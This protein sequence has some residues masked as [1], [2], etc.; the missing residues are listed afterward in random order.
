M[1]ILFQILLLSMFLH[2]TE[3]SSL[4][5]SVGLYWLLI[6]FHSYKQLMW[7][8]FKVFIELFTILFLSY[9]LGFFA[10]RHVRFYLPDQTCT[11]C[12]RRR[13][14]N[15]WTTTEV[16]GYP[17]W[18]KQCVHIHPK[19]PR[20]YSWD[21]SWFTLL[22]LLVVIFPYLFLTEYSGHVAHSTCTFTFSPPD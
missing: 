20:F 15:H 13:S 18:I 22:N 17:F 3:Q 19:L 11:P 1:S 16:P 5:Y 21:F 4:C 9:V 8:I 12:I 14:L 10:A 2:N 7:T 6:L